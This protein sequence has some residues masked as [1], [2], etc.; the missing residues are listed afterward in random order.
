[1]RECGEYDRSTPGIRDDSGLDLVQCP[2]TSPSLILLEAE[3]GASQDAGSSANLITSDLRPNSPWQFELQGHDV[4]PSFEFESIET[5]LSINHSINL[6]QE[7]SFT[8]DSDPGTYLPAQSSITGISQDLPPSFS[9][10]ARSIPPKV[11][12]RFS[13]RTIKILRDWFAS[14]SKA[15]YPSEEEKAVLQEMT[16]LN[17]TQITNWLANT[18]RRE[19]IQAAKSARLR[20]QQPQAQPIDIPRAP[21]PFESNGNAGHM[22][23]L[24]RWV[25]SP[26]ENEAA[27][28]TAIARALSSERKS[29]PGS[30]QFDHVPTTASPALSL[31]RSSSASSAGAS[32]YGSSTSAYSQKSHSS[33]S[34]SLMSPRGR[35]RR[36]KTSYLSRADRTIRLTRPKTFQC[37]FC[38]ETFARRYD[39]QRHEKTFHLSLERWICAPEGCRV[40]EPQ[41]NKICCTFCGDHTP[42][43]NHVKLH[44]YSICEAKP[45]AERTFYRKD[46]L[47]QHLRLVHG[48]EFLDWCMRSW[49]SERKSV[50]SRCG[51]CGLVMDTW[52]AR[53]DHLTEHFRTGQTMANWEGDW[54]FEDVVHD[55]VQHSMPPYMIDEERSSPFPF[56]ACNPPI[57]SP[58][59]A[60]E[61][62]K[63][64]LSYFMIN[65]KEKV[66]QYPTDEQLQLEACRIVFAS[67]VLSKQSSSSPSWL[68]DL[69]MASDAIAEQAQYGPLRSSAENRLAVLKI[70]GKDHL[71]QDCPMEKLLQEYVRTVGIGISDEDLQNEACR[72]IADVEKDSTT[73][74]HE[75]VDWL[76]RQAKSSSGWLLSFRLRTPALG[77]EYMSDVA[78]DSLYPTTV[79]ALGLIE[80]CD[81]Y[82]MTEAMNL[83][84]AGIEAIDDIMMPRPITKTEQIELTEQGD[85]SRPPST[86]SSGPF[87]RQRTGSPFLSQALGVGGENARKSSPNPASASSEQT[88]SYSSNKGKHPGLFPS[89]DANSYHQLAQEL[90]RFVKFTISPNNPLQHIP[91]D[92]ELQHRARCII[93]DDDDPW[94]QTA[95]DNPE[96]LSRF[97]LD[98]GLT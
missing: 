43:E 70:N 82:F 50:R 9:H 52:D 17:Q 62:I 23:P 45:L 67:E 31:H 79:D 81:D 66:G 75:F 40:V 25:D 8:Y 94:N 73:P 18:R 3:S 85:S 56:S 2:P 19:K 37:T 80:T 47:V 34:L 60:Y 38:T 58:P 54:G 53:Q 27:S 10:D 32:S 41:T 64:E 11:G 87:Q 74:F 93:Y 78:L 26:P 83:Y 51:F 12:G 88:R 77:T 6:Q 92:E 24:E 65:Y 15:P 29:A 30:E 72:I 44:N 68:R 89:M 13:T 7:L 91:T 76:G 90:A 49:K 5:D 36:K 71:F 22:N 61:L 63:R 95:A 84:P 39:W 86:G 21:T 14:H 57:E 97:K 48:V 96:W 33:V 98:V 69:I 28:I 16:G 59:S 4:A 55:I 1:M 42:D 46:H 35:R 20:T